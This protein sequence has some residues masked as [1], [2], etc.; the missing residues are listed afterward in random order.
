M[1]FPTK[2]YSEEER[3]RRNTRTS[4]HLRRRQVLHLHLVLPLHH[5]LVEQLFGE[6]VKP[7]VEIIYL[8]DLVQERLR[9]LFPVSLGEWFEVA[10]DVLVQASESLRLEPSVLCSLRRLTPRVLNSTPLNSRFCSTQLH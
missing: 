3:G 9:D 7:D 4:P 1:Q 2:R 10:V 5:P 6:L 8:L